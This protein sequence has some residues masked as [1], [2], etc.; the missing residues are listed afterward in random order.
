MDTPGPTVVPLFGQRK[1]LEIVEMPLE[2]WRGIFKFWDFKNDQITIW[3]KLQGTTLVADPRYRFLW[4]NHVKSEFYRHEN[5][6][7]LFLAQPSDDFVEIFGPDQITDLRPRVDGREMHVVHG[8]PKADM[9]G[10]RN[11]RK[12]L[13]GGDL[14]GELGFFLRRYLCGY[15]LL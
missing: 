15:E 1:R 8:V 3:S 4:L 5:H 2:S 6:P 11:D 14:L 7:K 12:G 9:P 13:K 10:D